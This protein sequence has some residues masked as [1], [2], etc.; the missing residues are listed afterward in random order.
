MGA[1]VGFFEDWEGIVPI[2][3]EKEI[4]VAGSAHRIACPGFAAGCLR[5]IERHLPVCLRAVLGRKKELFFS[6]VEGDPGNERVSIVLFGEIV[7]F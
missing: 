1:A 7:G 5:P 2:L 6:V 4:M 3:V